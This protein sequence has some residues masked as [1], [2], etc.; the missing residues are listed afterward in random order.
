MAL[1]ASGQASRHAVTYFPR[2]RPR[3][4]LGRYAAG[5]PAC[6]VVAGMLARCDQGGVWH[7]MPPV[8]TTLKGGLAPLAEI[9]QTQAASL[10]RMGVNTFVRL[11]PG[12]AALQGNVTFAGST[13]VD[14]LWQGL[15]ASRLAAFIVRSIE[16]DTRWVFSGGAARPARGGPRAASVGVSVATEAARRVRRRDGRA[17]VLRPHE[18]CA[19]KRATARD[20]TDRAAHRLRAARAE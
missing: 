13:T 11:L 9:G 10:Q 14:S 8:D 19:T 1:R 15:S 12:V 5:M 16:A 3:G 20:V 7:R 18:R 6:G 4:D 17:G 2:V